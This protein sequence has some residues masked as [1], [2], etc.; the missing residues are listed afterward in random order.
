MRRTSPHKSVSDQNLRL[1]SLYRQGFILNHALS[2]ERPVYQA[3]ETKPIQPIG[4][5]GQA[6]LVYFEAYRLRP[7]QA[8]EIFGRP[9]LLGTL[10][11]NLLLLTAPYIR[12]STVEG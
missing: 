7:G 11:E 2:L 10:L 1:V 9:G 8:S 4:R 5:P 12:F 3:W 6:R